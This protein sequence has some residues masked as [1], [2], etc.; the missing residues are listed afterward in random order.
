[1]TILASVQKNEAE[2][3]MTV[4]RLFAPAT[5]RMSCHPPRR[6]WRASASG[7]VAG[8]CGNSP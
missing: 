8:S 1:M 2:I 5:S 4:Q 3:P 7:A 6:D